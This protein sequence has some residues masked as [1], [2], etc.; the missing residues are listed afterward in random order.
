MIRI[1]AVAFDLD[2]TLFDHRGSAARAAS[3]F[4][5]DLGLD[6]SAAALDLWF[7]AEDRCFEQ[8]RAGRIGFQEQRRARLRAVLPA[9][10]FALDDDE[11]ELDHLFD[12]YLR[13]Y[14]RAWAPFPDVPRVL[15]WLHDDGFGLGLLTNGNEEQQ[16]DKLAVIGIR[17][18]FDSVCISEA[19]GVQKP[20]P[21]AFELLAE[22]LGCGVGECLF[23]GDDP[24][25]DIDGATRAGMPAALIERYVD[26]AP[27]LGAVVVSALRARRE[28]RAM[29]SSH[30]GAA[31][32]TVAASR[33]QGQVHRRPAQSRS[34]AG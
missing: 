22:S 11:R 2:G 33:L 25:K 17:A 21:R 18:A 10:G 24:V 8:W 29:T 1:R 6:D 16:L 26:G 4:L 19:I 28:R 20:D 12:R 3:R 31:A 27:D 5:Q 32:R 23:V 14:R 30:D 13:E 15:D 9:L 7:A 34:A